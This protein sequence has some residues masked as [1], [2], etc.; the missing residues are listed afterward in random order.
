MEERKKLERTVVEKVV[1]GDKYVD[2]GPSAPINPH[3]PVPSDPNPLPNPDNSENLPYEI[4][5][6][7]CDSKNILVKP[8]Y[9]QGGF[10][11]ICV[12]C[13]TEFK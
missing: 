10:P 5:C 13:H 4:K 1:G 7:H 6:P 3:P 8:I 9:E 2:I 12:D 11:Y